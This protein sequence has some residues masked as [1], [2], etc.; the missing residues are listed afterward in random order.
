[1]MVTAPCSVA[2]L[3]RYDG[4]R[5]TPCSTMPPVCLSKLP[6][7]IQPVWPHTAA[8]PCQTLATLA[9]RLYQMVVLVPTKPYRR[10]QK[11]YSHPSL[12]TSDEQRPSF[13]AR[14]NI[15]RTSEQDKQLPS[16]ASVASINAWPLA[17]HQPSACSHPARSP[18]LRM[19]RYKPGYTYPRGA[20]PPVLYLYFTSLSNNHIPPHHSTC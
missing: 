8:W 2:W 11:P 19:Y 5:C 7:T 9:E 10:R 4:S 13:H 14:P 17:P 15:A 6:P 1:M 20:L 3:L 18:L 16:Q 12:T